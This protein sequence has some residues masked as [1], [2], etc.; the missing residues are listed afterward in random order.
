MKFRIYAVYFLIF[1]CS[2]IVIYYFSKSFEILSFQKVF[3][4]KV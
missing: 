3:E 2:L 1:L 4:F